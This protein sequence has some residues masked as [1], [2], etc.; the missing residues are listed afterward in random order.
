MKV[1]VVPGSAQTS[2]SA[3][4]T[5]L[6]APSAPSVIG[7]YRN[8]SKVPDEFKNHPKFQPVPGDVSDGSTLDFS[9]CD[10]VITMTPPKLDGSDF[11]AFG[12][13]VANNVRRAVERSGSVKRVVYVSSQRTNTSGDGQIQAVKFSRP[14]DAP[15]SGKDGALRIAVVVGGEVASMHKVREAITSPDVKISCCNPVACDRWEKIL[16]K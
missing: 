6:D 15:A 16:A 1:I 11:I 2:R 10:A 4:R 12:K 7:V 3:I 8:M 5:L 14:A 9:G 13:A